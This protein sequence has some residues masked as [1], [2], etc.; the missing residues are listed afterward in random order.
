MRR[1]RRLRSTRA[2]RSP[3]RSPLAARRATANS[4]FCTPPRGAYNRRD[5]GPVASSRSHARSRSDDERIVRAYHPWFSHPRVRPVLPSGSERAGRTDVGSGHSRKW[6]GSFTSGG[7]C[8]SASR[9][10]AMRSAKRSSGYTSSIALITTASSTPIAT[11]GSNQCAGSS[12]SGRTNVRDS[13]LKLSSSDVGRL[14]P[15]PA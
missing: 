12:T 15:I 10:A 14:D 13:T 8:R 4:R 2:E 1:L 5:G 6:A 9:S 3:R 11:P 7:I